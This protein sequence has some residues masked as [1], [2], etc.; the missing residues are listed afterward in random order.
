MAT[1]QVKGCFLEILT[2]KIGHEPTNNPANNGGPL[3]AGIALGA[4][5]AFRDGGRACRQEIEPFTED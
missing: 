2:G 3:V 4:V 1:L 5:L